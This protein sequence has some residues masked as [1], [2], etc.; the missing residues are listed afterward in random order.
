MISNMYGLVSMKKY[1]LN[2][3]FIISVIRMDSFILLSLINRH[4]LYIRYVI[5][6]FAININVYIPYIPNLLYIK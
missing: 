5:I 1:I 6:I 2:N 4:V 3:M